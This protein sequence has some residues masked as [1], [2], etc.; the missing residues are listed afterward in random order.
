MPPKPQL[1]IYAYCD[2]HFSFPP[3][4]MRC[5]VDFC[6]LCCVLDTTMHNNRVGDE[7]VRRCESECEGAFF[8]VL[9]NIE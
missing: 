5:K 2:Q 4:L 9:D 3:A 6:R 7:V 1:S 8:K